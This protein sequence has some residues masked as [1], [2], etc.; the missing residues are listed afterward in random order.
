L[1]EE[2]L[3]STV[4]LARGVDIAAGCGQLAGA[5]ETKG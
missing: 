1:E 2:R 3:T 4:R 5:A